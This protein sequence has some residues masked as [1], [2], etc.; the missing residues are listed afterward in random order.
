MNTSNI[1]QWL[2]LWHKLLN[3]PSIPPFENPDD[4]AGILADFRHNAEILSQAFKPLPS[5][6]ELLKRV[7]RCMDAESKAQGIYLVADS[8]ISASDDELIELTK[9]AL[10]RGHKCCDLEV[11]NYQIN[12]IR[13]DITNEESMK[14]AP[15]IEELGD[16]YNEFSYDS[17][18]IESGTMQFL[19]EALY[20]LAASFE[21]RGYCLTPLCPEEVQVI[22][23]YEPQIELWLRG[24]HAVV[25][26]K[27]NSDDL[28]V[29]IFVES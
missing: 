24:A 11:P 9:D 8:L 14:A 7:K 10:V 1:N 15:L 26:W 21:V 23:P 27:E 29:D 3:E 4:M 13:R 20:T 16:L 22:D 28:W 18:G 5:G 12:V 17:R 19:S 25:R 2:E 6:E